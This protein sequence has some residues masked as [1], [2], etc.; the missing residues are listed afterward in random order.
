MATYAANATLS[1]SAVYLDGRRLK[2]IPNS[3]TV[4]EPSEGS[5][6]A[7]TSG[8][9]SYEI[10]HGRNVESNVAMIS[11]DVANTEENQELVDD[12]IS[13]GSSFQFSTMQIVSR[14]SNKLFDTMLLTNKPEI[15]YE[16]EGSISLEFSGRRTDI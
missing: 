2:Y 15:S 8:G 5:A 11:F 4:T 13:R 16:A 14:G 1:D 10:V 7:V 12:Y 9:G 6:R 3:L